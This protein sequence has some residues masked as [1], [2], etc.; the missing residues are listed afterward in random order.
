[1]ATSLLP[2][3]RA[4][5]LKFFLVGFLTLLMAVPL[6]LVSAVLFERQDYAAEATA[7][8]AEGWGGAQTIT[9]P[10]IAV[11]YW[12]LETNFDE[13]GTPRT[14][15][16]AAT[17]IF[18]PDD[19]K[20]DATTQTETR[21]RGIFEVNVFRSAVTLAGSFAAPDFA[22]IGI[23]PARV[24]WDKAQLILYVGDLRGLT[25]AASLT[26]A[27]RP[28]SFSP[29]T[30]PDTTYAQGMR[31]SVPITGEG[32]PKRFE[33]TL[34]LNG[35]QELFIAPVGVTSTVSIAGDWPHPS[36]QGAFL[37]ASRQVGADGFAAEW[38]V[39]HL[40]RNVPQAMANP[41]DVFSLLG[42]AKFGVSFYQP[43]DF[44]QTIERALKYAILFVGLGFLIFFLMETLTGA[45]VHAVQYL[46]VGS[47]QVVFYLLLLSLSENVGFET[48]YLWGASATVGLIALYS[49]SALKSLSRALLVLLLLAG[50]YSVLY[51]LLIQEDYALLIGSVATF[52][53][54]ALTMLLTRNVDW[55]QVA[56]LPPAR[57]EGQA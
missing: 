32:G 36:F 18:L 42:S 47:A 37:P 41:N 12:T 57:A 29:G 44:Y 50:L 51:L 6:L 14:I 46:L 40:A 27:G 13:K 48:A 43:V 20:L 52:I 25:E 38:R 39:P 55:Y 3:A 28:L 49:W 19:F 7:N 54:L 56:Q 2:A 21:A 34:K 53:A 33:I 11:P 31:A 1:M 8:I 22:A 15:E 45:R 17:A 35:T 5:G 4:P 9:G 16:R 23:T 26:W 30:L 10:L 24:A